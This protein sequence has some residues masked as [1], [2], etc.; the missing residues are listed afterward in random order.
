[1][2][3]HPDAFAARTMLATIADS[4]AMEDRDTPKNK[5]CQHRKQKNSGAEAPEFA[6]TRVKDLQTSLA[7]GDTRLFPARRPMRPWMVRWRSRC[8]AHGGA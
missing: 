5:S 4:F 2:V 6:S 1:M 3:H 7:T 8:N